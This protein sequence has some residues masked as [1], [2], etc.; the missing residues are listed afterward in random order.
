MGRLPTRKQGTAM[1]LWNKGKAHRRLTAGSSG[2]SRTF[3]A[4]VYSL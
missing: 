4:S 3:W 1:S 2:E